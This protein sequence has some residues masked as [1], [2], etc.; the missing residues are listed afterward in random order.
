MS[1]SLAQIQSLLRQAGWPENQI[2]R[3]AA[4]VKYESGGNPNAINNGSAGTNEHS[5]G[6]LQI[7]TLAHHG[8]TIAQLE[9]PI[10]N[11]QIAL[12]IWRGRPNYADWYN[13]NRKYNNDYQ[14]IASQ[15]LAVYQGGGGGNVSSNLLTYDPIVINDN[16]QMDQSGTSDVFIIAAVGIGA[17]LLF[18][19]WSD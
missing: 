15:S 8:Y 19:F 12:S 5:V 11:L 4:I 3:A 10:T 17:L 14:G 16:S 1:Y 18:N 6:L 7:N 9:D 2:V 13:S